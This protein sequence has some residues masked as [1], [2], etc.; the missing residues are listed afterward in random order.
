MGRSDFLKMEENAESDDRDEGEDRGNK[1][2]R[3]DVGVRYMD[4]GLG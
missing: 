3:H 1:G 4:K 2:S